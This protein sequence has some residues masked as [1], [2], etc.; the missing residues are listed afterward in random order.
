VNDETSQPTPENGQ[1][2]SARVDHSGSRDRSH[3]GPS[4]LVE[5]VELGG[6]QKAEECAARVT[7]SVLFVSELGRSIEF[8]RV[9]FSCEVTI[10]TPE[11]ALLLAPGGFQIYLI[12]K[13]TRASHPSGG[14]GVQ[15]LI[16]AVESAAALAHLEW[17]I[18]DRRGSTYGTYTYLSG[19][20]SFLESRDP[21]GIRIL[22][23]Y[24]SPERLPR[25]LVENRL[26]T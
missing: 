8:Y 24:P 19:G 4:R 13:G 3:S 22:V 14:I 6:E 20:V 2:R 9:I 12:A 7:S 15:C 21:D 5:A 26:Y 18:K 23:A 16:W 17:A 25:T 10:E 11:A 1:R